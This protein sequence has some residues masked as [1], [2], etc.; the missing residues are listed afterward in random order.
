MHELNS[1]KSFKE[2]IKSLLD[3]I[4]KWGAKF[5]DT[6]NLSFISK[7]EML[8]VYYRM[9]ALKDK[10]LFD[11]TLG[12]ESEMSDEI[13]IWTYELMKLRKIQIEM[14]EKKRKMAEVERK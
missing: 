3:T 13:V 14:E 4:I 1:Y 2:E 9:D 10:F 8:D 12:I 11:K 7:E 5:Q 6:Q